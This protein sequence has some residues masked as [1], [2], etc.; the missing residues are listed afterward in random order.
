MNLILKPKPV[1]PPY[2]PYYQKACAAEGS[3]DLG[4]ALRYFHKTLQFTEIR[5]DWQA[6]SSAMYHVAFIHYFQKKIPEAKQ[7]SLLC[8]KKYPYHRITSIINDW[9]N[10]PHLTEKRTEKTLYF[11]NDNPFWNKKA[12]SICQREGGLTLES[13]MIKPLVRLWNNACVAGKYNIRDLLKKSSLSETEILKS[14]SFLEF[15]FKVKQIDRVV[16]NPWFNCFS[17]PIIEAVCRSASCR[18]SIFNKNQDICPSKKEF[19]IVVARYR[20]DL[21]WT[22]EYET[23][24]TVYNKGVPESKYINL[25]NIG[26]EFQTYLY[27][28]VSRYNNLSDR[29]LF[30]QGAPFDHRMFTIYEYA[31][32]RHPFLILFNDSN[33]LGKSHAL[34]IIHYKIAGCTAI[35]GVDKVVFWEKYINKI[36]PRMIHHNYGAQFS[37]SRELIHKRPVT[38]YQKL[39]NLSEKQNVTFVNNLNNFCIGVLFEAFWYYIFNYPDDSGKW[40]VPKFGYP[41]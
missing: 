21:S 10:K 32:T 24:I 15:L 34:S 40:K 20:E 11:L 31:D 27:H 39:L 37:V 41:L 38:Y 4:A 2:T 1:M 26:R 8:L 25:P 22:R 18:I 28:I 29:T 13:V 5:K 16:L 12:A 30:L 9:C 19:E 6:E 7:A 17:P 23:N 36:K 3:G 35:S 14:I 33:P